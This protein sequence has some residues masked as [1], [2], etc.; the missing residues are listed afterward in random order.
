[1]NLENKFNI[2]SWNGIE[3]ILAKT[4]IFLQANYVSKCGNI[5]KNLKLSSRIY[6]CPTCGNIIDRD[7][8]ASSNLR[9]YGDDI[10]SKQTLNS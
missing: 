2:K 9:D 10:I 5:N 8:Q 1:M 6:I 4:N 7:Y 3:F